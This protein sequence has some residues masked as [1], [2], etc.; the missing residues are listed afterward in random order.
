MANS[1][2][3]FSRVEAANE[4][5][6]YSWELRSVNSR[7]LELNFR[8]PEAFTVLELQLRGILK[9]DFSRGKIDSTLRFTPNVQEHKINVNTKRAK[10]III[11]AKDIAKLAEYNLV[12]NPL[13]VLSFEGVIQT[14][15][16]DDDL[17]QNFALK[18]FEQATIKLQQSRKREGK[19]LTKF[20]AERLDFISDSLETLEVFLPQMS[21]NLRDKINKRAGDLLITIDPLRLE[22]EIMLMLQKT[23]VAEE[24]D[25]LKTHI[26][27]FKRILNSSSAI[28]RR[29]DFLLQEL[30]R[31]TNTIGSKA[32]DM[33][34]TNCVIDIKVW[35]EQMREQV[36]NIE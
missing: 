36:Q 5:G 14:V 25:R 4:Q 26:T 27:E 33:R 2:T 6:T 30:I 17:I 34:T 23:D 32:F 21:D 13:E 28:G 24:I 11:V 18:I 7:F 35:V 19:Q 3:A 12:L 15:T 8:L 16:P 22:Q 29:L 31:E 10:E 20:I 9:K 1:M